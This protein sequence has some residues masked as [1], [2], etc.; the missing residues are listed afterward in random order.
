MPFKSQKQRA[1]MW[2]NKPKLAREWTDKYG[3]KIVKA[4]SKLKTKKE[5]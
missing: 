5:K 2:A 1:F 3:S 4:V